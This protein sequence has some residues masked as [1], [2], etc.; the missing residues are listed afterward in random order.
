MGDPADAGAPLDRRF[1][2]PDERRLDSYAQWDK[3]LTHALHVRLDPN[4]FA[5]FAPLHASRHPLG[6]LPV[7]DIFLRPNAWNRNALDPRVPWYLQ[8]LLDLRLV[9]LQAVLAGLLRYSSAHAIVRGGGAAA[10]KGSSPPE[11]GA[12]ERKEVVRWKNSLPSD[13]VIFY[14]LRQAVGN[15]QAIRNGKDAIEVCL[16]IARWMMLF[17]AASAALPAEN[18]EDVIMGG[19]GGAYSATKKTRDQVENARA[20]FVMLLLGIV[21]NPVV[22]QALS[23][24]YAKGE[25]VVGIYTRIF[26]RL[27]HMII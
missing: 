27:A 3:F 1:M 17:T 26:G 5:D 7:A 24:P 19:I 18:E 12:E 4:K 15:G 20:G 25:P 10:H 6:P 21:E 23:K 9:D 16:M 14:R 8:T 22:L 13:E 11:P 2:T